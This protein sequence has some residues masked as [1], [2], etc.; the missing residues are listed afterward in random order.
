MATYGEFLVPFWKAHK[1]PRQITHFHVANFSDDPIYWRF[2]LHTSEGSLEDHVRLVTDATCTNLL[3][4]IDGVS[5]HFV[6]PPNCSTSLMVSNCNHRGHAR[7]V[8]SVRADIDRELVGFS[9]TGQRVHVV[10]HA[11]T[12]EHREESSS[13]KALWFNHRVIEGAPPFDF[14]EL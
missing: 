6:L 12:H 2:M 14:P 9:C 11:K 8:Y 5:S 3:P 7:A 13:S 1:H 4:N 10:S